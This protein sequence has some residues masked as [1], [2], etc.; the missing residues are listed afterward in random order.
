MKRFH[1]R[2]KDGLWTLVTEAALDG[3]RLTVAQDTWYYGEQESA[4]TVEMS[5][6]QAR[7]LH[8]WLGKALAQE[9]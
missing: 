5:T 9:A 7:R 6:K 4:D 3:D 2:S 1:S 8:A